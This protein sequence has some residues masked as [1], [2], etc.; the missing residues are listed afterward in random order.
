M[1]NRVYVYHNIIEKARSSASFDFIG[2]QRI[3]SPMFAHV[4]HYRMMVVQASNGIVG[5][6]EVTLVDTVS[7]APQ[8]CR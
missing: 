2:C 4:I 3:I 1:V 8:D 5:R 6:V 7:S